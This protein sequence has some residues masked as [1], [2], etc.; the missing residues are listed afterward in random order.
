MFFAKINEKIEKFE[1]L[2]KFIWFSMKIGGN[3]PKKYIE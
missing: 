3:L 2:A 1:F